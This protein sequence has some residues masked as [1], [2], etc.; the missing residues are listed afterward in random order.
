ML[1]HLAIRDFAVVTA[2]E[3]EFDAGLTVISGETGAGKSL[4]VDALGFLSGQRADSGM[5][6]HGAERAELHAEFDLAASDAARQWLLEQE[7]DDGDACQLRRTLRADGGSRAWINGRPA[8][9]SQL[10]TLA[11][12]LVEIH[13][14][15][16][17]QAL[18]SRASQL[19]LL[20]A[21]GGHGARLEA[22]AAAAAHWNA[23]LRE[24]DALARAR[25][26]RPGDV[27]ER[28][29]WLE[30]QLAE[31]DRE[32]ID[33]AAIAD[34]DAAHRRQAH[35]SALIAACDAALAQLDGDV[36]AAVPR[37][38]RQLQG[39]LAGV[40][41]HEPR[42][43]EVDAM[44][45]AAAIQIDEAGVLLE[46]IR[47]DLDV[48]PAQFD[49]LER[50]IARL[51]EL[52]RKHR[53]SPDGLAAQRDALAAELDALRNAAVRLEA[54]DGEITAAAAAWRTA[55]DALGKA[56]AKAGK[57]LSKATTALIAELGMGG[58]RFEVAIEPVEGDRPDPQ[59]GE[60]VEFLVS[61]NAGQ[62]PRP[63]RKVA[64]G[65]ELS[66]ISLAI[67]VAALGHDAVPTMVFDEVDSGIGGAT[68][69]IVG[70]KLR[71]LGATRQVL[72]V[73]HLPQVAAQG[74][75]HYRV[76]KAQDAGVTRSAVQLLD[77]GERQE[78]L[79]RM[80]GGV[81]VSTEARAAAKRLLEGAEAG[82]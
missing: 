71:A 70:Q 7:L 59:G 64:S 2:A 10:A 48:D 61:A 40:Q 54:L 34:L 30:H 52:S 12:L 16:E 26:G 56:R 78:E 82:S 62:P 33:P 4:L 79:A 11:G 1:T 6:R 29:E 45:D 14:Q 81:E 38:L 47:A 8:P 35:S 42:L 65:G 39:T 53:V 36:H 20:D 37:Q 25:E 19:A 80:L 74:H 68:A 15:H 55:A 9:L 41:E 60:R 51:H 28:G 66:R 69:E 75:R 46:R 77:A 58:G 57:A 17:H 3:L 67:E 5:V 63:L 73:T 44:L 43:A 50:R 49:E 22:V 23:L 31:L 32:P 13:G 21:F 72:C 24:R 18:L 76:S 27:A